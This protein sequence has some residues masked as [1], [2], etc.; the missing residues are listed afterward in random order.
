MHIISYC[1]GC[2]CSADPVIKP[3]DPTVCESESGARRPR[4]DFFGNGADGSSMP[5]ESGTFDFEAGE[6]ARGERGGRVFVCSPG[7]SGL[8]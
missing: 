6:T 4:P 3:T 7:W 1:G 2:V 5:D 8:V